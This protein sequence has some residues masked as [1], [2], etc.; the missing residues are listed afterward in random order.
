MPIIKDNK[1]LFTLEKDATGAQRKMAAIFAADVVGY[2][3][4]MAQNEKLTLFRLKETRKT[5]DS[6]IQN[7]NGRIFSTA[8]DSIMAEFASPVDAVEAAIEIQNMISKSITEITDNITIEFRIGV[9]LGDIMVQDNNLYGDNVNIAARLESI[10]KPGEICISEKVYQ[11][12]K[13]KVD[14]NFKF[15]GTKKLKNISEKINVYLSSISDE[16][17][18]SLSKKFSFRKIFIGFFLLLLISI[19]SFFVYKFYFAE[20]INYNQGGKSVIET[21]NSEEDLQSSKSQEDD[22]TMKISIMDFQNQSS[23]FNKDSLETLMTSIRDTLT[24]EDVLST[25]KSPEGS[26]NLNPPEVMLIATEANS[27]FVINGI[28]FSEKSNNYLSIKIYESKRGSMIVS[29]KINLNKNNNFSEVVKFLSLF[30][31]DITK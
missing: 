3:K 29:K 31:N 30:K 23:S 9:N 25:I 14:I 12:I 2:S 15:I 7:L 26:E 11:E 13:N 5:T 4:L 10:S 21:L 8:G 20:Q 28:I 27:A 18:S 6:I 24:E 16:G 22:K 1:N 17:K 19:V